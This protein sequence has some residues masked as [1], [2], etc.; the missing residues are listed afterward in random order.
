MSEW[1]IE[2][3]GLGKRYL[4]EDREFWPFRGLDLNVRRGERLGIVGRN[5]AGKTTLLRVLGRVTDPT[6][7]RAIVR[8]KTATVLETGTGFHEE[9]TGRENIFLNGAILGMSARELHRRLESIVEFAGVRGFVD[10]PIRTYSSGMRSRLSFAIAA[11]LDAEILLLDEILAV[12]D[13]A[14]QEKCVRM[15]DDLTSQGSRTVVFVSHSLGS[16]QSLCSRAILLEDG[17]VKEDGAPAAVIRSY[18][19]LMTGGSFDRSRIAS[20]PGSGILRLTGMR[21]ET[22]S[23]EPI[24]S[25][26]AGAGVRLVFDYENSGAARPEHVLLNA[27]FSGSRGIRLFNTSTDV[28]RAELGGLGRRGA[29]VC[30]LKSL[31]LLPG[32]YDLDIGCMIDRR[33]SDRVAGAWSVSVVE[34]DF[35][36]TGR[37]PP[38][39]EAEVLVDYGWKVEKSVEAAA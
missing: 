26:P 4:L 10:A 38:A 21:L 1:A 17:A 8:G 15:I 20:R 24:E 28:V 18:R 29:F 31:P 39:G 34:S 16:V 25:V 11:H 22:L 9:L 2:A 6:E 23:G 13:L 3:K 30:E 12:G 36:G 27:A 19:K 7:G 5:G 37:L 33:L 14:F 35:Y 32:L